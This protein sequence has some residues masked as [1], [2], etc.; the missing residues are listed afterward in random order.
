[1]RIEV[2]ILCNRYPMVQRTATARWIVAAYDGDNL[3]P[4][5]IWKRDGVV[6]SS[7]STNKRS[8]VVALRDALKRFT[9]PAIINIYIEDPFVR[10]MMQTNMPHR[11]SINRW[12]KYRYGQDIKYVE[13]WKEIYALMKGHAIR[14]VSADQLYGQQLIK[15]MEVK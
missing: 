9:K 5:L 6:V 10:H 15:Q 1:M 3:S 11:W 2:Y 13:I 14:Y 4:V 12:T 8:S 7:R